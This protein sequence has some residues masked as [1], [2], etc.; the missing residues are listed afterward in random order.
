M[1]IARLPVLCVDMVLVHATSESD[2]AN[3]VQSLHEVVKNAEA[4]PGERLIEARA[5][6]VAARQRLEN[7]R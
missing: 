7:R 5:G 4:P 2:V 3:V 1:R 6:S